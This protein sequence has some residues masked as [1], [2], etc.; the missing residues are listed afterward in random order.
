MK[1]NLKL[2]KVFRFILGCV[3]GSPLKELIFRIFSLPINEFRKSENL[4]SPTSAVTSSMHIDNLPERYRYQESHREETI[5]A[6]SV[7]DVS[8][9]DS[10][11]VLGT[12]LKI[13]S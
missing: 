10:K 11:P 13:G 9:T 3:V 6:K 4:L 1:W 8:W 7:L 12:M 2:L 5:H